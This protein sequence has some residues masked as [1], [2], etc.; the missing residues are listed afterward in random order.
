MDAEGA[1]DD[2]RRRAHGNLAPKDS[3]T[4]NAQ[5]TDPRLLLYAFG[6]CLLLAIF[7]WLRDLF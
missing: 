1:R 4:S 5:R 6:A 2:H 7:K 3:I